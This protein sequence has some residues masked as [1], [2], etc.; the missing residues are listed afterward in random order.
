VEDILVV[1]LHED[2]SHGI[3]GGI[4]LDFE[5]LLLIW[6]HEDWFLADQLLQLLKRHFLG[7]T[8]ALFNVLLQKGIEWL[9]DMREAPCHGSAGTPLGTHANGE[10]SGSEEA[11]PALRM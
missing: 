4:N 2:S 9:C 11:C 6:L 8:K 1:P 7:V 5:L 3:V 10:A